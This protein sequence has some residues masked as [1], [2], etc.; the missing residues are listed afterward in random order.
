MVIVMLDVENSSGHSI[1]IYGGDGD[2]YDER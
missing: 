1:V 2:S